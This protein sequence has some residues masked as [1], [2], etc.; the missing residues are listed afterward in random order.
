MACCD[1]GVISDEPVV[2]ECPSCGADVDEYG[3]TTEWCCNYSPVE[4]TVCNWSPCDG[5]C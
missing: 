2:G 5:S 3:D 1:G 4:C